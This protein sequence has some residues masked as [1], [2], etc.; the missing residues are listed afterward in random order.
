MPI[1]AEQT[2]GRHGFIMIAERVDA[3]FE[4]TEHASIPVKVS[5]FSRSRDSSGE[6]AS[7]P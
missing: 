4:K 5:A 7:I 2:S 1:K 3:G 6:T